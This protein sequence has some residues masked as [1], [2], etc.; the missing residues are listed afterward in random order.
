MYMYIYICEYIQHRACV[1]GFNFLIKDCKDYCPLFLFG[2]CNS[3]SHWYHSHRLSNVVYKQRYTP[4]MEHI[5]VSA[6]Y[7]YIIY[8]VH[9]YICLPSLYI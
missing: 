2:C 5:F 4:Y 7:V 6:H 9:S 3:N 1:L 8:K